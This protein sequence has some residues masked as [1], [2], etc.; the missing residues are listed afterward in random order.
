MDSEFANP[1]VA[2]GA[3]SAVYFFVFAAFYFV[4]AF[5][6]MKI[7]EKTS[8]PNGWFAFVPVLNIV[9]GLQIAQKPTWWLV[10]TFVP[11]VNLYVCISMLMSIAERCG[12]PNWWGVVMCFVPVVNLVMLYAMAFGK[13][14]VPSYRRRQAPAA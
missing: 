11:L 4:T 3:F 14:N 12:R 6:F 10:L 13:S 2:M 8:T 5:A 7:A 1:E 9:L